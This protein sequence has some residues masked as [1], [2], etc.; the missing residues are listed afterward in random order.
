MFGLAGSFE[1]VV[2]LHEVITGNGVR[3]TLTTLTARLGEHFFKD[4]L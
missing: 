4:P 2:Y 1:E 3:G